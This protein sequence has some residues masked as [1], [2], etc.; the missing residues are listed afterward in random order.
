MDEEP[1]QAG[2]APRIRNGLRKTVAFGRYEGIAGIV[3]RSGVT[4]L[5]FLADPR[6]FRGV[7]TG[8]IDGEPYDVIAAE[9]SEHN[10]KKMV[11]LTVRPSAAAEEP[12]S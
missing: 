12:A 9:P 2:D 4:Q 6:D 7:K 11:V 5:S 1:L 8:T 3:V 10:P